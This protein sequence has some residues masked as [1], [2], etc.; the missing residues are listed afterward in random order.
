MADT[1]KRG[2]FIKSFGCQMNVYDANKMAELL[3]PHGFYAVDTPEAADMVILNTCYIRE[4][5]SEK[6]FSELGKLKKIKLAKQK[7]GKEF[8][9]CVAGCV[10]QAEGA[11]IF[12][13]APYVDIV[14]GPQSY[15]N[16]PELIERARR[17]EKWLVD[18]EFTADAKFD[19][20]QEAVESQGVSAFITIQEGCD[21]F[22]HFCVVPYT[23]GAEY[24]RSIWEI[25]REA[26]TLVQKGAREIILLGQNVNAYTFKDEDGKEYRL[27]HLIEMLAKIDNLFRIRYTT[28]HPIDMDQELIKAHGAIPKLMPMLHLPVQSGSDKVLKLMNRK[29]DRNMYIE[30]I[31][32]LLDMRADMVFSSDFIVGYPGETDEDFAQ[33]LDLL[34]QIPFTQG[35]SFKYSIRPGTPASF[36]PDQI[37]DDVKTARLHTLQEMQLK[38]QYDYNLSKVG[39]IQEVLVEKEGKHNEQMTGKNPYLQTVNINNCPEGLEG[40]LVKV[41]ITAATKNTLMGELIE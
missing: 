39:T 31:K 38:K 26:M 6:I 36:I 24:S 10:A 40:K 5:A 2:L 30:L 20:L 25:F 29:H 11:E 27:S 32:T 12:S 37:A 14:V 22:C 1:T 7:I 19:A 8:F 21:K 16:L 23:R 4:K 18:L 9:I 13:R 34:A 17:Q 28:S 3:A 35:Y 33:T 15:H 41:K